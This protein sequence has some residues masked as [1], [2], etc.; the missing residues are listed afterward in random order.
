MNRT[1]ISNFQLIS[2][3]T[4]SHIMKENTHW[5]ITVLALAGAL[6]IAAGCATPAG[7]K[8]QEGQ[9]TVDQVTSGVDSAD[10]TVNRAANTAEKASRTIDRFFK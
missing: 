8:A 10:N 7:Q 6:F 9:Q 1:Q 5:I 3:P 4:G 2:H